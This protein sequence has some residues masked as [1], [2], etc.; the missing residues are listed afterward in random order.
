MNR[1]VYIFLFFFFGTAAVLRAQNVG[2]GTTTP[3][4]TLDVNGEIRAGSTGAAAGTAGAGAL[5]WNGTSL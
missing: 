1:R 4:A 3:T 5:R 2:I